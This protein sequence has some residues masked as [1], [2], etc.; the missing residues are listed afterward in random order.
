MVACSWGPVGA[1][2]GSG[3]SMCYDIS[4]LGPDIFPYARQSMLYHAWGLATEDIEP[5][6]YKVPLEVLA[7]NLANAWLYISGG[8][9]QRLAGC[10]K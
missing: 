10:C 3:Q 4:A 5:S 9:S 2:S 1:F 8:R 7:H 6:V